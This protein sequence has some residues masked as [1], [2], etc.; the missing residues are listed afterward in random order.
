MITL[1]KLLSELKSE[2]INEIVAG[3]SRDCG[4][5]NPGGGQQG[6]SGKSHKSQKS[7]KSHKSHKSSKSSKFISTLG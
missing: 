2:S 1:E 3:L 7:Q 5:S 6:K 4:G